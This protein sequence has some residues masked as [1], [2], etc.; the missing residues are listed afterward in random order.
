[1]TALNS[2]L[3][4]K[5]IY[6]DVTEAK[7]VKAKSYNYIDAPSIEGYR[8]ISCSALY[9][10]LAILVSCSNFGSQNRISVFNA[11]TDDITLTTIRVFY[12]KI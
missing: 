7:T 3:D 12:Y 9:N 4:D 10:S 2:N 11:Y 1:M 5:I 8:M 6:R